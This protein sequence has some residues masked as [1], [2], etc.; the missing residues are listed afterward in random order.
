MNGAQVEDGYTR[1][2]NELMDALAR[3][4]LPGR[5]MQILMFIIRWTYGYKG[6]KISRLSYRFI[7]DGTGIDAR[8]VFK[9]C[10]Q[11]HTWGY[12]VYEKRSKRTMFW[13]PNKDYQ[14]WYHYYPILS[15]EA[16]DVGES[17]DTIVPTNHLGGHGVTLNHWADL[18]QNDVE[19]LENQP[20][21]EHSGPPDVGE[22]TD[23][24]VGESADEKRKKKRIKRRRGVSRQERRRRIKRMRQDLIN[25]QQSLTN[26]VQK[27]AQ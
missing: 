26:S 7:S 5:Y 1:I 20:K 2:A 12:L 3:T 6:N 16:P 19:V 21:S 23:I 22:S 24:N 10:N 27:I 11:L 17:A 4:P 25:Q 15:K 18:R 14:N 8:S 9:L 13:G